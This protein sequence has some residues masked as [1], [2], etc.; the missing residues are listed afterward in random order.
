MISSLL[1]CI[2]FHYNF[3]RFLYLRKLLDRFFNTYKC[4]VKIIIDTDSTDTYNYLSLFYKEKLETTQIECVTHS[5]LPHPFLLTWCH[6]GHIVKNIDKYD[7]FMYVEDDMDIPWENITHYFSTFYLLW[8]H[9]IPGFI[10]VEQKESSLVNTDNT[11]PTQKTIRN[12]FKIGEREFI[13]LTNSYHAFWILP[14]K[15]LK[16]T[17]PADFTQPKCPIIDL[18]REHAAWYL[19]SE[20]QKHAFIEIKDNQV[21]KE[22]YSFHLPNNYALNE[23]SE[24]GKLA[25]SNIIS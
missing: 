11:K 6:R 25:V 12:S 17:M 3:E 2:P 22:C 4:K 19:Q 23:K 15:E 14:Q 16:E 7:A 1:I 18:L 20:L 5:S 21:L 24:F 8:P 10:R 13:E 9:A